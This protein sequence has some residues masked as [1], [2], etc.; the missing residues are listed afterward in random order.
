MAIDRLNR[1]RGSSWR[2]RVV[3]SNGLRKSQCFERKAD[4]EQ[5]EA[6][7]K[8]DGLKS[9]ELI[10]K[11]TTFDDLCERFLR[12]AKAEL[13]NASFQKYESAIRIYHL[14]KFGG[15]WVED[16]SRLM[17][18]DFKNELLG[19]SLASATKRFIFCALNTLFK[20]GVDLELLLR[21][22]AQAVKRPKGSIHRTDFWTEEE[23]T[24]FLIRAK[25][26]RRYPLYFIALNTGMRLGEI[27]ALKWDCVN[28]DKDFLEI[29]RSFDQKTRTVKETTKTHKARTIGMNP[30]LK[31]FLSM[32]Y[33][34]KSDEFVVDRVAMGSK[35]ASHATRDFNSDTLKAGLRPIRF[36]DLRHTYATLF[37]GR[38]G[39]I[40]ALSGVLGHSTGSM[41]ARY[42][43]FTPEHAKKA[44][45]VV[46][47]DLKDDRLKLPRLRVAGEG[48]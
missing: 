43:H 5:W 13:S 1:K 42:A 37:A 7:L 35:N 27:L 28:F 25:S 3:L 38:G 8:A 31:E 15:F 47:F 12:S 29:R 46:S 45:G 39:S 33:R 16:I 41:T 17:V 6:R 34:N 18:E 21:N 48:L 22:P 19:T 32:L 26:A 23:A 44:A 24:Q 10:R 20:K 4:A 9:S 30:S 11:K 14:P 36:H 2:A 40:H